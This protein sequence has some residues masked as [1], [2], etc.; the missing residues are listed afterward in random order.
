MGAS[1]WVILINAC[2]TSDFVAFGNNFLD[3]NK[4]KKYKLLNGH[5]VFAYRH[6]SR[7]RSSV[8]A[9]VGVLKVIGHFRIL[10][11]NTAWR[12]LSTL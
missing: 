5:T 6:Q 7:N 9:F 10:E 11:K 1:K 3:K 2:C 4:P 12:A 8:L